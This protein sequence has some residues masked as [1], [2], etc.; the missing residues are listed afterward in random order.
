[1]IPVPRI[2]FLSLRCALEHQAK[3]MSIP[4]G[5]V[6]APVARESPSF[7]REGND[8][9]QITEHAVAGVDEGFYETAL[10]I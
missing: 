1:M 10:E 9:V 7:I 5:R 6:Q 8:S 3:H 4:T 2:P